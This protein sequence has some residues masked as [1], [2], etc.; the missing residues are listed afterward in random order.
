MGNE[1]VL[2]HNRTWKLGIGFVLISGFVIL[3]LYLFKTGSTSSWPEADCSITGSRVIRTV[4]GE[5]GRAIISYKGQYHLR[6]VVGGHE[7]YLWTNSGWFDADEKFVQEKV[8]TLPSRC[9]FRIRYNPEK[10]SDSVAE[11]K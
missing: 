5:A 3:A 1:T 4:A 10:P 8:E 2:H 11:R 7:Y 6:Y 9:E